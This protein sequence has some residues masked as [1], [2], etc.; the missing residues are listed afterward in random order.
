M[1]P[2]NITH[3]TRSEAGSSIHFVGG[4]V[5]AHD[6]PFQTLANIAELM[7]IDDDTLVNF[8]R[9]IYMCRIDRRLGD[10]KARLD[11]RGLELPMTVG[12]KYF[13]AARARMKEAK[14]ET[15]HQAALREWHAKL[16]AMLGDFSVG[17]DTIQAARAERLN[18]VHKFIIIDECGLTDEVKGLLNDFI[19]QH[20]I[21][22]FN[23]EKAK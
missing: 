19:K 6:A 14:K 1:T 9:C 17:H 23:T 3:V 18:G 12:P 20:H 11:V 13:H 22:T 4:E 10:R 21:T 8:D 15:P 7:Q 5:F 2:E 16:D